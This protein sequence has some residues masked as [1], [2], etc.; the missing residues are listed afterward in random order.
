M[1]QVYH[2]MMAVLGVMSKTFPIVI[3][4]N[5]STRDPFCFDDRDSHAF[6][7]FHVGIPEHMCST[8]ILEV[9]IPLLERASNLC[10][11]TWLYYDFQILD[12]I[13]FQ[14]TK[15]LVSAYLTVCR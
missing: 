9:L 11:E 14:G 13:P 5:W 3:D 12:R 4:R 7:T 8:T 10:G 6:A 2:I 15:G 1:P